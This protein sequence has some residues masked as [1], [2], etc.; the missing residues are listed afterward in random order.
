MLIMSALLNLLL[1]GKVLLDSNIIMDIVSIDEEVI[2][3][4]SPNN[5]VEAVVCKAN[6]GGATSSFI[7]QVYIVNKGK[8]PAGNNLVFRANKVG[9]IKLEW[10]NEFEL[11][12]E[13]NRARIFYY[14]NFCIIN[15]SSAQTYEVKIAQAILPGGV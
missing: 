14:R 5:V 13:Y 3:Q 8:K 7:Y 2:R 10:R 11:L 6:S 12:I 4:V 9:K 15:G 1:F